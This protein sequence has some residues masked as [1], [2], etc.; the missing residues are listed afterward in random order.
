M[1]IAT[2][3]LAIL[4]L[5]S[6]LHAQAPEDK[7][8][9]PEVLAKEFDRLD[10]RL[11]A[12]E[13]YARPT[14]RRIADLEET[15]RTLRVKNDLLDAQV[16]KLQHI[17]ETLRRDLEAVTGRAEA[18]ETHLTTGAP[19]RP[20]T[21]PEPTAKGT[22]VPPTVAS[23]RSQKVSQDADSLT[24]T[25]V[26]ANTGDKPLVFLIVQAELLDREGKLIRTESGY[27]D[28]RVVPP[29]SSATFT[30]KARRDPR[31]HDH[32]LSLRTE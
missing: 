23:I 13:R 30:L 19:T 5:A 27:T 21:T 32:R 7:E 31:I 12:V 15:V 24:I 3:G 26:V 14:D 4:S 18:I 29:G 1:R 10:R 28:P 20:P 25:G 2:L 9:T 17:L 16:K 11:A 8:W 22:P 6:A